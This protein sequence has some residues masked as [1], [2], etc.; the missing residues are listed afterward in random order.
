MNR[1]HITILLGLGLSV[2]LLWWALRDV[3]VG[4]MLRHLRDAD[5]WLLAAAVAAATGTFVLRAFRWRLLLLPAFATS[6]FRSRF[7]AV[8]VGFM[9]NNLLPARLGEFARAYTLSRNEP[10]GMS[11]A[12]ASLVVER[13]LD[14][15]VLVLFL[16]PGLSLAGFATD[17]EPQI[18]RHLFWVATVIVLVGFLALWLLVRFPERFLGV[19][20]DVV[21]RLF[22][23]A[24]ADRATGILVSFISGL[25]SLRHAH[26]FARV[27]AWTV[28]VWL[29]NAFSFWLGF[30]AFGIHGPGIPGALLLQSVIGFAVSLPSSPGFFGPLEAGARLALDGFGV[31]PA[32]IISFAAGYHITTFLPVTIL[33]LWYVHR[34][35]LTWSE[36]GHSE[37]LVEAE[38]ERTA[39]EIESGSPGLGSGGRGGGGS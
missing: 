21:H 9:A 17:R 11:S 16:L 22:P 5:P 12:F 39:G 38:V 10:I 2:A 13:L 23:R 29:W 30:R 32:L 28:V 37:E 26:L 36:V 35:G 4:E 34:L 25:G 20:R 3:S 31:N 24:M 8:C 7:S 14:G 33:G 18:L 15:M 1:R 27:L 19:F 6:S